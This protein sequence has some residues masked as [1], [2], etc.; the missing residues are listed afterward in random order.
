MSHNRYK[1]I[2]A[3]DHSRVKVAKSKALPGGD[4]INANFIPGHLQKVGYIASQG[5]VPDSFGAFWHMAWE[6]G[7]EC[8]VMV[9]NEI[10]NGNLKC[11]RYWPSAEEG[12]V[13]YGEVSV[14]LRDEQPTS[15]F[16]R[17]LFLVQWGKASMEMVHFQY[18]VWPDHGVP[19]TTSELLGFRKEVRR[20]CKWPGP[21]LL[22][23][24]SAGVGRTGT[25]MAVDTL[26]N[27]CETL[28]ADVDPLGFVKQ[29][30]LQRNFMVQAL[31]QYQFI[32]KALTDGMNKSLVRSVKAV[33]R[34]NA[35]DEDAFL[36][37]A[38]EGL[39]E[40]EQE[41][42]DAL[43]GYTGQEHTE[44]L[45]SLGREAGKSNLIK[46]DVRWT[47]FDASTEVKAAAAVPTKV[48]RDSLK[49]A[50][51]V[52]RVRG[53]VPDPTHEGYK[54]DSAAALPARVQSLAINT[55]PDAWR[56][57]Y[58]EVAQQWVSDV[59][60]VTSALN[61][62]ESRLMSLASQNENWKLRGAGYR[63]AIEKETADVVVALT[64]RMGSLRSTLLTDEE[65]W[66]ARLGDSATVPPEKPNAS[67][68]DRLVAL[69]DFTTSW[70]SRG[71]GE[72]REVES[73]TKRAAEEAE[74]R[75]LE[76]EALRAE[77]EA[78]QAE[79]EAAE[80]EER[81]RRME[82]KRRSMVPPVKA[83]VVDRAETAPKQMVKLRKSSA[84]AAAHPMIAAA[85][86]MR[87]PEKTKAK[88][89]K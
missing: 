65:R 73:P 63:T 13:T 58:V 67:L 23:H 12:T 19:N 3:Y 77:R 29:M 39:D 15:T 41:I 84:D 55:A 82:E 2:L 25:F 9:T 51:D 17:R 49:A 14:T 22:V 50:Q 7:V 42:G 8:I 57:R 4:Y 88:K 61:P 71:T 16:I 72:G 75:R 34:M 30:R 52:W 70:T 56:A 20:T 36:S 32:F 85:A 68:M 87:A 43:D 46:P 45:L 28:S 26:L 78:A 74:L 59:Y 48:R 37:A 40:I 60:D 80:R 11:H 24:C 47:A 6:Q 81:N 69:Q 76:A 5:P 64:E 21:P 66:K 62:I 27:R 10:E 86:S 18:T 33:R 1:N 38:V 54:E 53:N 83:T 35:G 44:A 89:K 31:V 79:R